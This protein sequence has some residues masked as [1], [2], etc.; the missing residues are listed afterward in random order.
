MGV[1]GFLLVVGESTLNFQNIGW[2]SKG[3]ALFNYVGWEIFRQSPWTNPIG[4]NPNYGLE[5]S[6]SI[7]YSDSVPIL[8]IFF[9]IFSKW[10]GEPFQYF[11]LWL[12]ICFVLQAFFGYR[13][14]ELITKN[15]WIQLSISIIFLFTPVMFFRTN[16]HLALAGQF[17]ILWAIYLNFNK[18][19][20]GLS[21]AL[22]ITIVLGIHFYLF[23]IVIGLWFGSLLDRSISTRRLR[24]KSTLLEILLISI[25]VSIG[26]WQY[27][28]LA[29]STGSSSGMGYGGD[30]FNLVAFFN[31]L[32]WSLI[33]PNNIFTPPTIEGF[34]YVG[35]G[36]V[37]VMILGLIQLAQQNKRLHL[38]QQIH[39]YQFMLV[40]VFLML[41][42][43]ISNNIDIGNSHYSI[44][45]S[46]RILF[47]LN[48]VRAS[49]RLS[50]PFQYLTILVA[51]WLIIN[52]NKKANVALFLALCTLQVVD[53]SKGWIKIHE[54]FSSLKSVVT[55]HS[56][57]HDFWRGLSTNYSVIKLVPPQ[58]WPEGWN[59]YAAYAVENKMAT[60]SVFLARFDMLKVQEAKAVTDKEL[61]SG[62]LNPKTIY[63]FQKWSDN[64]NQV[65]PK[66]DSSRDLLARIDG[67]TVLAPNYKI[68]TQCSRV[69]SALEV[70]SIVPKLSIG[71]V[72]KFSKENKGADLL[73]RGWTQVD[74]W[75][76]WS[77]GSVSTL[78]LPLSDLAPS[79][80][81]FSFRGM[82]GPKH[83]ITT[84]EVL[85]NGEYQKTIQVTK[86][87]NNSIL[88]DIP[89]KFRRDKFI[90]IEFKHLN[91][92]SPKNAGYGNEDD[93]LLTLGMES[94][95]LIR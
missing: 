90:V 84:V 46:E 70:E 64:L 17:V 22:L 20:N 2:L 48:I 74:S 71:E 58:N 38:F 80:I 79:Q 35:L 30:Q 59:T 40:A 34:A 86:Q 95:E 88:L 9:K 10:L 93:R 63:V 19:V 61:V 76:V 75:G 65:I 53:T 50:W 69:D 37:G 18:N 41:I 83:Q 45:I 89:V 28:Y 27:G 43:S 49:A 26:A 73:L 51:C 87:L 52:G 1:I 85:I 8:A 68:C 42:I 82:V 14:A 54:Y 77:I 32:S 5:F 60:N 24:T 6:S 67:V 56:L 62:E 57:A 3:D 15:K 12:L 92:V 31:P 7:V 33:I 94:V 81:K 91:P 25:V 66:F 47:F 36:V 21:W 29:I 44:P 16:V 4:L 39:Q 11:G 72:V 78:A 13:L 55:E 23:V